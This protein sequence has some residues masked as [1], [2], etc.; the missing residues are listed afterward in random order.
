[1]KKRLL[2]AGL[3]VAASLG[4]AAPAAHAECEGTVAVACTRR[5]VPENPCTI[6]VCVVWLKGSCLVGNY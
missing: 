4:V 1:M 6:A 2:L 5:C 3:A